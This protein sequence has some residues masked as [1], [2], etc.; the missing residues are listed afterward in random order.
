MGEE[1]LILPPPAPRRREIDILDEL[2]GVLG[3]VL[4]QDVRHLHAWAEA[5]DAGPARSIPR[6]P[7]GPS[8]KDL[9]N[10]TPPP[11]VIAKRAEARAQC[12]ELADALDLFRSVTAAP[13]AVDRAAVAAACREVVEWALAREHTQTAIELAEAAAR[14]AP[15]DPAIAN[16]AGRVTRNAGEY[17]RAEAWF[18][19]A[20]GY[21]R[22]QDDR[23]ELT[24][25]HLGKGILCKEM[26]R[27]RC[28]MH[29][30]NIGS[31]KARKQ[32][33]Q[34]LAAEVQHDLMLL[35]TEREQY[36]EAE[37]H[38]KLALRWYGKRHPRFPLFAADVALLMVMRRSYPLAAR[39]SKGALRHVTSP[40]AR[41][42]ILAL[43]A[44]ALAG[45]GGVEELDRLR[46][47][48]LRLL[49]D[50]REKEALTLWHLAVAEW[51]AG[52]R[53][54]AKTTAERA[55]EVAHQRGERE[56][57]AQS[58][59]LLVAIRRRKTSPPASGTRRDGE[60]MEFVQ[61][62]N[63]RLSAW[64][65]EQRSPSKLRGKWAA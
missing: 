46:K 49:V 8:P 29:H 2:P 24:R 12:G 65:P 35:L 41:A 1:R 14:V 20:I 54:A 33:I 32:G 27:I 4:W 38:A 48:A 21:A 25:A 17:A 28:A 45:C 55:L 23:V 11:W 19:R 10:P 15:E 53:E 37:K 57:A 50:Y 52:R 47:R 18:N 44:R 22:E 6:I 13:L 31:R 40:G 5:A 56:T 59:R 42:V 3:L 36:S 34:W 16:L 9:F 63:A 7:R 61:T 51:L 62:L 26:G 64:S 30:F 58:K 43:H 39:L 60:F